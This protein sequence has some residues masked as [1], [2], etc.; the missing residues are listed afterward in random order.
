LYTFL[1]QIVHIFCVYCFTNLSSASLTYSSFCSI[2]TYTLL[3]SIATRAVVSVR[4]DADFFLSFSLQDFEKDA[5]YYKLRM[6]DYTADDYLD[7]LEVVCM[8]Y[9]ELCNKYRDTPRTLFIADPS[10]LFT[11]VKTYNSV[12]YWILKNY[13]DVLTAMWVVIGDSYAGSAGVGKKTCIHGKYSLKASGAVSRPKV[14]ANLE[15][16]RPR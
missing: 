14:S 6:T 8:D 9:S 16:L 11:N 5:L 4:G 10:Y 7:G 1:N 13:L 2:P 12:E 15:V 3:S